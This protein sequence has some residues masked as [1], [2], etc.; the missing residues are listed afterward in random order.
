MGARKPEA[1]PMITSSEIWTNEADRFV[2][3]G[4]EPETCAS[5][6]SSA[7]LAGSGESGAKCYCLP[8]VHS[9]CILIVAEPCEFTVGL[10]R[11]L[12]I[13]GH[14]VQC[15]PTGNA[16]LRL[17]SAF[18]PE[19]VLVD[20]SLPDLSGYEVAALLHGISDAPGLR[21]VS[22]SSHGGTEDS[23]LSEAAGCVEHLQ[24][25]VD[26]AGIEALLSALCSNPE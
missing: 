23:L 5:G 15:A 24:R 17:A 26:G 14:V 3:D 7:A 2:S 25:P 20:A 11:L 12:R 18:Q 13:C 1:K 4:I 6:S 19:F 10:A 21:I 16:A 22:M 8:E 9:W